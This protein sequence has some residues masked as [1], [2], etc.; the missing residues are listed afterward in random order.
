[1]TLLHLWLKDSTA[2][3]PASHSFRQ[4]MALAKDCFRFLGSY[5]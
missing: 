1:M 5:P 2:V 4:S 3:L